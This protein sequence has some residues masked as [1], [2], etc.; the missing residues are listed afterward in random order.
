[1]I[2]G[3]RYRSIPNKLLYPSGNSNGFC[4][5]EAITLFSFPRDQSTHSHQRALLTYFSSNVISD[6]WHTDSLNSCNTLYI[7]NN[8]VGL[9]ILYTH[10]HTQNI[11]ISGNG[12]SFPLYSAVPAL[13]PRAPG[14]SRLPFCSQSYTVAKRSVAS[15]FSNSPGSAAKSGRPQSIA[16]ISLFPPTDIRELVPC[17][18]NCH[19]SLSYPFSGRSRHTLAPHS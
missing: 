15:R 6:T 14:R 18:Q 3:N 8:W 2:S 4:G 13:P 11:L 1:M 16:A 7:I 5:R 12:R 9:T 10:T 19:L 17:K